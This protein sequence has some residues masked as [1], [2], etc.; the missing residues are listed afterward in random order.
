MD[1][2]SLEILTDALSEKLVPTPDD[3][4]KDYPS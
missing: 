1:T 4:D 2:Q 3:P